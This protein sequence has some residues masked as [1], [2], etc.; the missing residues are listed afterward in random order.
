MHKPTNRSSISGEDVT[1]ATSISVTTQPNIGAP[2]DTAEED[3]LD[4]LGR[5]PSSRS[6]VTFY[7]ESESSKVGI[8]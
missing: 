7:I 8:I 5:S 3:D 2:L 1:A 6:P 4:E